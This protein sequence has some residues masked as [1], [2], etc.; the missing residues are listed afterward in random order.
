MDADESIPGCSIQS[1]S[2][3]NQLLE[4]P[5]APSFYWKK[6]WLHPKET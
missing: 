5:F 1:S 2:R 6:Q 4:A 3:A